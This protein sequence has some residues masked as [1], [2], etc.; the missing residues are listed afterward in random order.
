MFKFIVVFATL[1]PICLPAL[2]AWRA[3]TSAPVIR[4]IFGVVA[5]LTALYVMAVLFGYPGETPLGYLSIPV[6]ALGLAAWLSFS[7]LC[8]VAVLQNLLRGKPRAPSSFLACFLIVGAAVLAVVYLMP[9][10]AL[11]FGSKP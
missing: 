3:K 6:G 7:G 9:F 10:L 5:A 8:T 11:P 1:L 4:I 2:E